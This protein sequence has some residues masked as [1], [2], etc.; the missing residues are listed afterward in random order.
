[1]VK[2]D[3][4]V[5][6]LEEMTPISGYVLNAPLS[7]E[8]YEVLINNFES[9]EKECM[10]IGDQYLQLAKEK[11]QEFTD[12]YD[13]HPKVVSYLKVLDFFA[14]NKMV[15]DAEVMQAKFEGLVHKTMMHIESDKQINHLGH[16]GQLLNN[17][18]RLIFRKKRDLSVTGMVQ[19]VKIIIEAQTYIDENRETVENQQREQDLNR[20]FEVA[21]NEID[22][23]L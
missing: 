16:V 4:L 13:K 3:D 10:E 8:K 2:R 18:V 15:K 12:Q 11:G 21:Q 6:I 20:Q 23:T 5:K 9:T 1:M 7:N 22:E 17:F 19:L 14:K